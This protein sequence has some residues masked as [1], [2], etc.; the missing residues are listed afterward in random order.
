MKLKIKSILLILVVFV[1]GMFVSFL[2]L[3]GNE[4]LVLSEDSNEEVNIKNNVVMLTN[5]TC[6]DGCTEK[7]V[8]SN[9]EKVNL[10]ADNRN[11]TLNNKNIHKFEADDSNSTIV[12]VNVYND[13]IIAMLD[14]SLTQSLVV[15]DFEGGLLKEVSLFVDEISR[16]FNMGASYSEDEVFHVDEA[17]TISFLGTKSLDDSNRYMIDYGYEIDLCSTDGQELDDEEIVSGIFEFSYLGDSIF[18]EIIYSSTRQVI[19]DIKKCS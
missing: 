11:I 8:L 1:L 17:G 14:Y 2:I 5:S 16:V 15:Y 12:Q 7:V 13:I 6:S 3:L 9:G 19:K 4:M 18:S 10:Y